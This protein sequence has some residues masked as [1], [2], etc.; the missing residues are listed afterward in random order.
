LRAPVLPTVPPALVELA[1]ALVARPS[2]PALE[3][4]VAAAEQLEVVRL[5]REVRAGGPFAM[6]RGI[7]LAALL[8]DASAQAQGTKASAA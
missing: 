5:V 6:R 1:R 4:L 2:G 8:L 7:E 3:A